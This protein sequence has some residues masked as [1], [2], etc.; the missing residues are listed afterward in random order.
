VDRLIEI[1]QRMLI[2]SQYNPSSY[3]EISIAPVWQETLALVDKTLRSAG[4]QVKTDLP[5]DLPR[6][7]GVEGL[8][9]QVLLNLLLNSV[10]ALA[11]GGAIILAASQEGEKLVLTLTNNGPPIPEE[12]LA[13]IF[14]PFFTSKP[15]G[16]GLGLFISQNI[17]QQLGGALSVE[18]LDDQAGVAFTMTLP[19]ASS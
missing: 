19:I 10:E 13:H 12:H 11:G 5:E 14:E 17:I 6:V 16:S 1:T 9:R 18:N 15:G 8:I 2:F 3:R 7:T 4:V